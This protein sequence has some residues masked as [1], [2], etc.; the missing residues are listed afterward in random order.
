MTSGKLFDSIMDRM[1]RS[2]SLTPLLHKDEE[3]LQ[4]MMQQL[5]D[6]VRIAALLQV[7]LH[8]LLLEIRRRFA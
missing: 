2:S 8:M 3:E 4:A 7:S 6:E 1:E 5:R